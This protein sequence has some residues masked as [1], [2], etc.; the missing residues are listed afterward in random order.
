MYEPAGEVNEVGGDFYE[1]FPV[2]GGWAV[3]LG[4]VS[5]KGAA[6]AAL[7]AEARH[8]IRTAG[9]LAAD[10][11]RGPAAARPQ[12]ARPR[13]RRALL[14][15]DASSSRTRRPR[16]TR[17]SSTSPAIRTR[18][19]CATATGPSRSASPGRCSGS[20]RSPTWAPVAG[21]AR[22]RRPARPLHRRRDRGAAATG[23][24]R[25]G[26]ERLRGRARRLRGPGA[27]GRAGARRAL[28]VRRPGARGRRRG[29]RDPP[30]RAPSRELGASRLEAGALPADRRR[31]DG[32]RAGARTTA[33]RC[34]FLLGG[35]GDRG[36]L[37]RR[38]RRSRARRTSRSSR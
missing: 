19:C 8:T 33:G 7:T 25:F 2:E 23:G 35:A 12:P 9:T 31:P 28:G 14:G 1:V 37:D 29:G 32:A 30:H 34:L 18:S 21:R 10:P 27:R 26:S 20:S 5:G 11:G 38:S 22:A 3:V 16:P 15:R 24:E 17:C 36:R 13:R 6:A 4:D